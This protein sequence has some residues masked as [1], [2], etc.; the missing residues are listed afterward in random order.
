[1]NQLVPHGLWAGSEAWAVSESLGA[2]LASDIAMLAASD[3]FDAPWYLRAYPDVATHGIDPATHFI[4]QGWQEDR[5]PNF[6]FDPVWYRANNPD[7]TRAG[8]NPILHYI[9]AGEAEGRAPCEHFDLAWYAA[10]HSP[11]PEQTLLAHYL[12]RSRTGAVSPLPEFDAAY[13]LAQYP[14]IAAAGVDPFEHFLLYGYREGRNPS[15][16]FDTGFY[17]HRYLDPATDENPV[18]HYRRHRHALRLH[19]RPAEGDADVFEEVRRFTRSGPEFETFEPLPETA[20]RRAEVLA[21]YLPQF[22]PIAENDAWW[23]NGFTEWTAI[24]RGM[25]RFAGHYQPRIPRD[26]GHYRLGDTAEAR[27]TMR[28]QADMARAAGLAGFVHYFYWFNRRR[29]LETPLDAMLA[30]PTIDFPFCLMWANENWTRRWDG[31]D[32][33][34]LIAQDYDPADDDALVDCFARHMAD[35]RYIRIDGRPL[36]MIYRAADIPDPPGTVARWR[37]L[38]AA[39]HQENPLLVMAQAFDATDPRDFGFDAAVE[40][41]PHKL[42]KSLPRRNMALRLFDPRLSAHVYDYDDLVAA[43]LDEPASDFPLIRTVV[44]GWDNDARRQGAGL[45]VRD[46]S[47]AKYQAWL[48]ELA[49]RA[50]AAPFHGTPLVCVNAWNEWAEGAYLEPDQ[51]FGAAYLNATARALTR[52]AADPAAGKLLLVG[53]DAFPA[54]AQHLLCHLLH[55]LRRGH[56]ID[57]EYLLL[58]DGALGPAYAAAAPGVCVND[59]A[60]VPDRI[61]VLAANWARRGYTTAL[62]NTSAAAWVIPALARVGIAAT[63]LVHELPGLLAE[64]NLRHAVR[65]GAAAARS[66]VFPAAFVRDRFIE[67]TGIAPADPRLMPQSSYRDIEFSAPAR[68]RL[69]ARLGLA[70]GTQ[71]ILGAGYADLRKGFD[72]FLHAWRAAARQSSAAMFCWLGDIDPTIRAYLGPEIA[73]AEASGRFRLAGHQSDVAAWFSAA[74]AFVLTS[75]EDPYPSVVLEALCAGLQVA[76]FAGSG[77]I[78]DLLAE[79]GGGLVVPMADA[80]AL[81]G[82]ALRLGKT[83]GKLAQRAKLADRARRRFAFAPYA[84]AL[85]HLACPDLAAVSVMVLS[86]NYARYLPE[87]LASVFAQTYPVTEVVLLDDASSD[88]SVAV[89]QRIATEWRRDLRIDVASENSGSVFH[90]W[91]RAAETARGDF[92]WIAEADDAADPGLLAALVAVMQA[93]PDIDLAFSDSRAIDAEGRELW[94]S[95]RDY[96]ATAGASALGQDGIFPARDFARRFLAERNLIL[97]VSAVLWRRSAL[98]AAL[99]RCADL[100]SF[101]VA[102]DWRLYVELMAA[103]A[104]AVGYVATPLNAH[105]R[106]PASVTAAQRATHHLDEIRRMHRVVRARLAPDAATRRLQAAYLRS[107]AQDLGADREGAGKQGE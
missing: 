56:G 32:H 40:F 103:S 73:A 35:P 42:A 100:D 78:P 51:Y 84:E 36:L 57:V 106:H 64:K 2:S 60:K 22:H 17:I 45:V 33:D 70:A 71:L 101:R 12:E 99:E 13:Y 34:V 72:L 21:F 26:L 38:F 63:L 50:A 20:R 67:A 87:R 85:L 8:V 37:T 98:L 52:G 105:R 6:Y 30:D 19:T 9:S 11:G 62:V 97:N 74:D 95:Y 86:Y 107:I 93:Q 5:R 89:A 47:P 102:G 66:V 75:R 10:A 25:P 14:D 77:G 79:F 54:G 3:L 65:E 24:G 49:N 104:G 94:P 92:V 48:A 88:N 18:I 44:P 31:S 29:L 41:P 53:H 16:A 28:R 43:S 83:G 55:A 61:V 15:A 1:M 59:A 91:R 68:T 96:C 27:A 4:A 39:R 69:R 46:S 81:A 82:A 90:Q 7:V 80:D 58:G 23:G 76:A